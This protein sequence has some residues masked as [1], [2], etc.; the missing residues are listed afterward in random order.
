MYIAGT[1]AERGYIR[2]ISAIYQPDSLVDAATAAISLLEG[3]NFDCIEV[4]A[5]IWLVLIY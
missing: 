3:Q 5:G 2:G 4:D 1:Q